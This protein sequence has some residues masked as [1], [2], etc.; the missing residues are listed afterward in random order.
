M[1]NKN[2]LN[3]DRAR[4]K[5]IADRLVYKVTPEMAREIKRG[6][7]GAYMPLLLSWYETLESLDPEDFKRFILDSMKYHTDGTLPEYKKGSTLFVV[8]TMAKGTYDNYLK[9]YA[10]QCESNWKNKTASDIFQEEQSGL[11]QQKIMERH[12]EYRPLATT[13]NEPSPIV[14]TCHQIGIGTGTAIGT[15]IGTGTGTGTGVGTGAG[16]GAG[17]GAGAGAGAGTAAELALL[18]TEIKNKLGPQDETL[19]EVLTRVELYMRIKNPDQVKEAI[20]RVP[21]ASD[22]QETFLKVLQKILLA[23]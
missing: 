13:G 19:E 9:S 6:N 12:P 22:R 21:K 1:A 10:K 14:T 2:Q 4:R 5:E 8:W 23:E 17:V 20:A 16:A 15:G 7:I 11:S 18:K 3:A